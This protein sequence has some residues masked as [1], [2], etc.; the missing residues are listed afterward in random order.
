MSDIYSKIYENDDKNIKKEDNEE[1]VN[2]LIPIILTFVGLIISLFCFAT[3]IL[4]YSYDLC[5]FLDNYYIYI[6]A[7]SGV[8][9][10][11]GIYFSFKS[12]KQKFNIISIV[13]VFLSFVA[14]ILFV[15]PILTGLLYL[16]F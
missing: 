15:I 2:N 12:L 10:M 3:L 14:I 5:V 11:I 7:V 16:N 9:L 8:I 4:C 1:K 6:V 13:N